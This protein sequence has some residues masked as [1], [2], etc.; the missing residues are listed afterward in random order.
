MWYKLTICLCTPVHKYKYIRYKY[1]AKS[2]KK[3]DYSVQIH[4]RYDKNIIIGYT[5]NKATYMNVKGMYI[6][7]S[8]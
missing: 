1:A 7:V 2:F 8:V 5:A 3:T 6:Y 4:I